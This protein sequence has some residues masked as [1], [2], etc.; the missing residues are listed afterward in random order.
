MRK[1]NYFE[2]R[3]KT[4]SINVEAYLRRIGLQRGMQPDLK[5]LRA[6]HRHHLYNIPF[7]NL[8]IHLGRKIMLSIKRIYEKVIV[9]QRGGF[10][11]ELNGLFYHLLDH[12]GYDCRLISA[13]VRRDDGSYGPPFDHMAIVV[14]LKDGDWLVDVGFGD[15]F[16]S[17]KKLVEGEVQVDYTKY[18]KLEKD[19]DDN[20][21]LMIS[22]DGLAYET[23]YRFTL[24]QREFIEFIDML[25][26]HQTSEDSPFTQKK[27]ITQANDKGRIT[28]T[29]RK[30]K[31]THLGETNEE[32]LLNDDEFW[33]K[34]EQHFGI[35]A[36]V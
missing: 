11:Y 28:L 36:G 27:L 22:S 15:G 26:Y 13:Q 7:E 23:K 6:L 31:I 4:D 16:M 19:I 32:A 25:D 3:P 21:F 2:T 14:R 20:F 30:L 35:D 9:N 12:L 1:L 18:V 10:C 24:K 34:C 5:F 33:S 29:D 8:D 17:P